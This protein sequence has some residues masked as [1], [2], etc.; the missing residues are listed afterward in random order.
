M[1]L[2]DVQL[3]EMKSIGGAVK[4]LQGSN[5]LL[6]DQ[7]SV[8]YSFMDI[9]CLKLRSCKNFLSFSALSAFSK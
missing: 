7:I 5:N 8:T 1:N 6:Y 2:L 9:V 3:R 4:N